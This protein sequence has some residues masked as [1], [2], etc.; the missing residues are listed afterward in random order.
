MSIPKN[1]S[2]V[3]RRFS[4]AR[5]ITEKCAIGIL[6]LWIWSGVG[7]TQIFTPPSD[8]FDANR[9]LLEK[10]RNQRE[11]SFQSDSL[12]NG[13]SLDF[14]SLFAGY[15]L[16][17][18]TD[19]SGEIL[20]QARLPLYMD[21]F[22]TRLDYRFRKNSIGTE[23]EFVPP[24]TITAEGITFDDSTLIRARTPE[25]PPSFIHELLANRFQ[26]YRSLG[27][28]PRFM[29]TGNRLF[30][31]AVL[32]FHGRDLDSIRYE[33]AGQLCLAL[34][35]LAQGLVVYAGPTSLENEDRTLTLRFYLAMKSPDALRHH[36]LTIEESFHIWG[37][38]LEPTACVVHL[39]PFVRADNL[40]T[41]Y[42]AHIE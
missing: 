39:Y 27:L 12:S 30:V 33:S 21:V 11:I 8:L 23:L 3:L 9:Q 40:R 2:R 6:L 37:E 5:P 22:T 31:P 16:N 32:Y 17:W 29:P 25:H 14:S 42:S 1:C 41:L 36:F 18:V 34:R 24:M 28:P 20:V 19:S 15:T 7:F 38:D 10:L 26:L 13:D 4:V 35:T